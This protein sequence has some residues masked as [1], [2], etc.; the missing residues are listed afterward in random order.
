MRLG[1]TL[2]GLGILGAIAAGCAAAAAVE[3][4]G[5]AAGLAARS[6]RQLA[7]GRRP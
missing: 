7:G 5:M 2:A 4:T 6:C 3:L 1:T